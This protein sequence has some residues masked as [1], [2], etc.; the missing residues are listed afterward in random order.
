VYLKSTTGAHHDEGETSIARRE[1][2]I[3]ICFKAMFES[4]HRSTYL[5]NGGGHS[6]TRVFVA[7]NASE[8]QLGAE[9]PTSK[10]IKG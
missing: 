9:L 3:E 2:W 5:N 10:R 7:V 6:K 4:I 1:L 8:G